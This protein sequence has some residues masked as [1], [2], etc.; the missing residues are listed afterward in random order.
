MPKIDE[1]DNAIE[2]L[3]QDL[4]MELTDEHIGAFQVIMDDV[5]R[6]RQREIMLACLE[7]AGVDCWRGYDYSYEIMEEYYPEEYKR[8]FE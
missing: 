8:R 5:K 7:G 2:F 3:M 4:E 1:T 6:L